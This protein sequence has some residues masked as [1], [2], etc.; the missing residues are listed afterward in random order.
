MALGKAV[1]LGVVASIAMP[2]ALRGN[3]GRLGEW[4]QTGLIPFALG[5]TK[6]GWSLPLFAGVTLFAWLFLS[7]ADR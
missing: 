7:W 5:D 3:S 4:M 6:L 1:L 2:W